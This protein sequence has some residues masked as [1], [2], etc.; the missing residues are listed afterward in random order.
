MEH[1]RQVEALKLCSDPSTPPSDTCFSFPADQTALYRT[2]E[3]K[4][5]RVCF[6]NRKQKELF[7]HILYP[8]IINNM[9]MLAGINHFTVYEILIRGTLLSTHTALCA[10]LEPQRGE[11]T[12]SAARM[13]PFGVLR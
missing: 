2:T 12:I 5:R 7:I 1:K 10:L 13:T 8:K 9:N 3:I 11:L 6:C 4:R